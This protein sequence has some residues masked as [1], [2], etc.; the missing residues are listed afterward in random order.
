V[1]ELGVPLA[2]LTAE[3]RAQLG[4]LLLPPQADN[5]GRSRRPPQAGGD[6]DRRR[7][8]ARILLADP[9]TAYGLVILTSMPFFARRTRLIGEAALPPTSRS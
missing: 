1:S 2:T 6:R 3:S 8:R 7:R 5:P 4:E 9:G